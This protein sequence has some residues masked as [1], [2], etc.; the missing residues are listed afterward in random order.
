MNC[1]AQLPGIDI[2]HAVLEQMQTEHAGVCGCR[3]E[4]LA[5]C[6]IVA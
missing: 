4:A 6:L 1:Q 5:Q 2:G 3:V